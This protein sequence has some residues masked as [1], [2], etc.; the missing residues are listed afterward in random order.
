MDPVVIKSDSSE[1]DDNGAIFRGASFATAR[2]ARYNYEFAKWNGSKITTSRGIV[3]SRRDKIDRADDI[4]K[5]LSQLSFVKLIYS[6]VMIKI[7]NFSC[8]TWTLIDGKP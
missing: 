1:S 6:M 4:G 7:I 8:A 3:A 5:A 2:M